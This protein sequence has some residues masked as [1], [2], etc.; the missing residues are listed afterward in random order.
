MAPPAFILLALEVMNTSVWTDDVVAAV[1]D[2]QEIQ[3][4]AYRYY[5]EEGRPE[6]RALDHWVRAEQS[7]STDPNGARDL[8]G[9]P[10]TELARFVAEG[11]HVPETQ[12]ED[13]PQ[14]SGIGTGVGLGS[15]RSFRGQR[16]RR[17]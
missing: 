9:V 1:P 17:R 4:L 8:N 5:L 12:S 13:K 16:R 15:Q 3:A 10:H 11:G 6:G 2:A 7:L 14:E